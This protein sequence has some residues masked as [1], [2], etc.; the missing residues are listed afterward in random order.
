ML[1]FYYIKVD[2]ARHSGPPKKMVHFVRS[3]LPKKKFGSV[4]SALN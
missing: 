1:Y 3:T 4:H 2:F